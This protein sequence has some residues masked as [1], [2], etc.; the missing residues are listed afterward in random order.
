MNKLITILSAACMLV[1]VMTGT[2]LR[3]D[4]SN[5]AGPYVG[6]SGLAAG[7]GVDGKSRSSNDTDSDMSEDSVT[8]GQATLATGLELG[9]ALPLGDTFLIDVGGSYLT[10]KAKISHTTSDHLSRGAEDGA[11]DEISFSIDKIATYYIAPSMALSDTA[12]LYV[13]W[14]HSSADVEV[15]GDITTPGDLIGEKLAVGTRI[16]LDSGLFIRSEAGYTEY[17]SISAAGKGTTITSTT[18][19][20]AQPTIAYGKVSVGFRF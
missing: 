5:F 15:T 3:A 7:A 20:S 19:Y 17:N 8:A 9:Y 11:A 12:S 6:I 1:I 16:V 2:N 10:G 4:S 18:S 13:K 14:G